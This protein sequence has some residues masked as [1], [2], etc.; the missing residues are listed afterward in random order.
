M[1]TT[2]TASGNLDVNSKNYMLNQWRVQS[3][4]AFAA[5]ASNQARS[6]TQNVTF[7]LAENGRISLS[8]PFTLTVNN[9]SSGANAVKKI[10]IE[11][12]QGVHGGAVFEL[13]EAINFPA[14]GSIFI[15]LIEVELED[16]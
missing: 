6:G 9:D 12:L 14:G 3:R 13:A 1:S 7:N 4:S 5:N 10:I 8:A 2:I 16:E 15:P 11:P